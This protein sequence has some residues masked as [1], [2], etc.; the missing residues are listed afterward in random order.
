M[1]KP[2]PHSLFLRG[3][4]QFGIV[5]FLLGIIETGQMQYSLLRKRGV[6]G[7]RVKLRL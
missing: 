3:E 6:R 1:K 5:T 7:I 2:T 4:R